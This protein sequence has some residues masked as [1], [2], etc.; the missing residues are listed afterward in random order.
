MS[1]PA[2]ADIPKVMDRV[3]TN[4]GLVVAIDN[5]SAFHARAEGLIS[6]LSLDE[7]GPGNVL[8]LTKV[9]LD[10]P[11]LDA[12]GGLV[13]AF[14]TN[15]QGSLD[16]EGETPLAAIF[17]PVTDFGAFAGAFEGKEE[18]GIIVGT[19]DGDT[20]YMKDIG[21]GYALASPNRELAA[22]MKP[23]PGNMAAH[24]KRLGVTGMRVA[25]S[26]AMFVAVDLQIVAPMIKEAG[27][28]FREQMEMV[29][30]MMG[31]EA[32]GMGTMGQM[33]EAFSGDLARDGQTGLFGMSLSDDG[34]SLD[35]AATF[36]EGS[37]TAATMS[38]SGNA[39]EL[40]ARVPDM[41]Y[42]AAGAI[43][44]SSPAVR[45]MF[46]AMGQ[47]SASMNPD[48]PNMMEMFNL[49]KIIDGQRGMAMVMG[50]PPSMI[51]GGL[52]SKTVQYLACD[53]PKASIATVSEMMKT[54]NGM[55]SGPMRFETDFKPAMTNVEGTSIDGWGMKMVLDPADPS[56]EQ[57]QMG[58]MMIFGPQM[59][60]SGY[61][62]QVPGGMITTYA[63]ESGITA[64][65]IQ[66][67]TRG[68]GLATNAGVKAAA[69][70]LPKG[71]VAAGFVGLDSL[72]QQ[73]SGLMAMGG[74]SLGVDVPDEMGAIAAGVAM[75]DGG[76]H[77]RIFVPQSLLS[78]VGQVMEARMGAGEDGE[79]RPPSR[80]P[81]S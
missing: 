38:T 31:D 12:T 35:L 4:A 32:Q 52:F 47:I 61:Y 60:L 72:M 81:R 17:L 77:A 65:A 80:R 39:I 56:A 74:Q 22:N 57:M 54:M 36:K 44:M 64:K 43:D 2:L 29:S 10:T 42:L 26:S 79:A 28:G 13:I 53:N 3:P 30:S 9:W 58:M 16:L 19:M 7:M 5:L 69:G 67:A 59:G 55:A 63:R 50:N 33:I 41:P 34:V 40:L 1:M 37:E 15:E 66:A 24:T 75:S 45:D 76:T 71:C 73:A 18:G 78:F 68:D 49:G 25:E 8:G 46:K 6:M 62:A 51:M 48:Q 20:I 21:G 23:A 11:G 27:A 14:L 70:H